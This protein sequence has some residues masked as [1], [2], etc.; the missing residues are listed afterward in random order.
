[1]FQSL[2]E[3]VT[4]TDEIQ[5]LNSPKHNTSSLEI[6]DIGMKMINIISY[7]VLVAE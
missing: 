2:K 5:Y 4:F 7:F 1:M 6:A 3:P